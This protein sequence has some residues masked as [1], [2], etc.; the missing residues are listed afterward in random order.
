M[1]LGA[2]NPR[3]SLLRAPTS[4]SCGRIKPHDKSLRVVVYVGTDLV[5]GR[6]SYLRE[7]IEGTDKAPASEPRRR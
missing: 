5:T 2:N 6:R 3:P 7:K 4:R 1:P